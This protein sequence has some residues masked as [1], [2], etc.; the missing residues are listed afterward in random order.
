MRN[1]KETK[2]FCFLFTALKK[3]SDAL[4]RFNFEKG[5]RGAAAQLR[6]ALSERK[7]RVFPAKRQT[8]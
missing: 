2:K 3:F 1:A 5:E 4:E 8:V 6:P 7:K